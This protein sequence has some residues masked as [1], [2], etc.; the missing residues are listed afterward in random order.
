MTEKERYPVNRDIL[1]GDIITERHPAQ[2]LPYL[3]KAHLL[4]V[5]GTD[6]RLKEKNFGR[7][8]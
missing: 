3:P 2:H 8:K 7:H 5:K 6:G 4:V 1:G